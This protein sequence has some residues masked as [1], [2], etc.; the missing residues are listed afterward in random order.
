MCKNKLFFVFQR[1][2]GEYIYLGWKHLKNQ[3]SPYVQVRGIANGGGLRRIPYSDLTT[4]QLL[5]RATDIFFPNGKSPL[6]KAGE[7]ERCTYEL[8]NFAGEPLKDKEEHFSLSD[9]LSKNGLYASRVRFYLLTTKKSKPEACAPAD[10]SEDGSSRSLSSL[11][12]NECSLGGSSLSNSLLSNNDKDLLKDTP[13]ALFFVDD[14]RR[15]LFTEFTRITSSQYS[16][17]LS[18]V[19]HHAWAECYF[20]RSEN[21]VDDDEATYHPCNDAFKSQ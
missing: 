16:G 19:I 8:G 17:L 5:Q 15:K 3:F 14:S 20:H 7:L 10:E 9:Y 11:N 18:A 6:P 1:R 12:D 2:G 21:F 13:R 4:S